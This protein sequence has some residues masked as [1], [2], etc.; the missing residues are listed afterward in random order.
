MLGIKGGV[1][2]C[3][4]GVIMTRED[5]IQKY[6]AKAKAYIKDLAI[7]NYYVYYEDC[8]LGELKA[9]LRDIQNE[10][11]VITGKSLFFFSLDNTDN[12]I[13]TTLSRYEYFLNDMEKED[14]Y[15]PT[16]F[17][18]R[19]YPFELKRIGDG[20]FELCSGTNRGFNYSLDD[21]VL[22]SK[23]WSNSYAFL[24]SKFSSQSSLEI[25][26]KALCYRE[27]SN[28]FPSYKTQSILLKE[29]SFKV[30]QIIDKDYTD[31]EL[32]KAKD[33]FKL[34]Y[35]LSSFNYYSR[36]DLWFFNDYS[37]LSQTPPFAL[38]LHLNSIDSLKGFK[39]FKYENN[40]TFTVNDTQTINLSDSEIVNLY[41]R[42]TCKK[43]IG[44]N[45]VIFDEKTRLR[46][47]VD[48]EVYLDFLNKETNLYS[49][50]TNN[51]LMGG[52]WFEDRK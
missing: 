33:F 12:D 39:W 7:Q 50:V 49:F 34:A 16:V 15:D 41:Y 20:D 31:E 5:A 51:G 52:K 13:D 47:Q 22:E 1:L 9:T 28:L 26:A 42:L 35:Y 30:Q 48:S 14:T 2:I 11:D 45:P 32:A 43:I 4:R 36:T 46:Y 29:D 17:S 38:G 18:F 37:T 8:G 44:A 23:E 10:L 25:L 27:K 19:T 3:E 6:R 24:K 40:N 21:M